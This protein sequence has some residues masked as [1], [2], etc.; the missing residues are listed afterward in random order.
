MVGGKIRLQE[1]V[2]IRECIGCHESGTRVYRAALML[3]AKIYLRDE[4][5]FRILGACRTAKLPQSLAPGRLFWAYR[6]ATF[7]CSIQE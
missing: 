1:P 5:L 7:H 2:S 4:V 3:A 6:T